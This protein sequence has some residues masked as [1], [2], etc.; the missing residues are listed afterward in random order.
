M[1]FESL[2]VRAFETEGKFSTVQEIGDKALSVHVY[3]EF[4]VVCVLCS[5]LVTLVRKGNQNDLV[6]TRSSFAS[7]KLMYC[8]L[9]REKLASLNNTA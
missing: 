7:H 8:L 3:V 6:R 2:P 1:E 9:S 4:T 5:R